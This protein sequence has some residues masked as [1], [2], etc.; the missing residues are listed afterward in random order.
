MTRIPDGSRLAVWLTAGP[1]TRR[2]PLQGDEQDRFLAAYDLVLERVIG[3]VVAA[4]EGEEDWLDRVR[5]GL[6]A[7]LRFFALDP[8]LARTAIVEI[9]A[10]GPDARRRYSNALSG[11]GELLE[12]GR[13]T[14]GDRELPEHVALMAV[15]AVSGLIFDQLRADRAERLPELLPD[16]LFVLLVPYVGPDV[17]AEQMR[18]TAAG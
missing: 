6:S 2:Q 1:E 3:E 5:A 13:E 16:L 7:L 14:A 11:L 9:Q 12:D 15:G 8:E 17:A 4:C 10:A 18:R